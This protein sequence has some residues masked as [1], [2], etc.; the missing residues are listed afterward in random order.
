MKEIKNINQIEKILD[1]NNIEIKDRIIFYNFWRR[2]DIK[3]N[4]KECWNWTAY[5]SSD[6]YGLFWDG[7]K[8]VISHRMAYSLI[9]GKIPDGLQVQHL[10]NNRRCCNP[11]HL[12]LGDNTKN[13][14]YKVKCGRQSRLIG[15]SSGNAKLM[16]DQVREIHIIYNEQR[17]LH[18]GFKQWQIVEPIAKK[19]KV[20]TSTIKQILHGK[21]WHHIYEENQKRIKEKDNK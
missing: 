1:E 21:L 5:A 12:E 17:K 2:V 10:C 9:K 15:E 13:V 6:G 16:E 20:S 18:P 7:K 3:D 14:R 4:I 11:Y 8:K 19:F